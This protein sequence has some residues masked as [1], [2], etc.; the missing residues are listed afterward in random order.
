[1]RFR[2]NAGLDTSQV[3]DRRGAGLG[4]GM[5]A[6]PIAVGGGGVGLAGPR[7]VRPAAGAERRR[8][9]GLG[10]DARPI[11]RRTAARAPTRTRART[12]GSSA[13][14]T[15]CSSTGRRRCRST[16]SRRPSSSPAR[17]APAAARRAPTSARSTA[18]PT[19]T[20]TSTSA[21][22]TSCAR[23]SARRAGRSP[24]H[25]CSRT[26][27]V[28][29]CRT[30]RERSERR[31]GDRQGPQS[32]SV[33]TELQADCFAGVWANHATAD[34][35]HHR[36]HA[37]GHRR[38]ARRRGGRRRRP[39]PERDAGPGESGDVDARL[40]EAA[41]ALVHGRLQ[42]GQARRVRHVQGLD[43]SRESSSTRRTCG[44]RRGRTCRSEELVARARAWA[45]RGGGELLV[46]FDGDAARGR[47]RPRS[48]RAAAR[49]TT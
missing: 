42:G 4:M 43:L 44:A 23:G 48:A 34:R 14:S 47:A 36:R 41:R 18:R 24:R 11:S 31:A 13:S 10:A 2:R 29:T 16:R 20:C 45:E 39:D 32:G 17:R 12:A 1:M 33:R 3:E 5:P 8:R 49:R 6:G 25:T 26:S 21:S 37:G 35:L 9:G 40:V 38:R 19:S 27:T 46:V 28:I 22:S 30:S 15:A 7:R